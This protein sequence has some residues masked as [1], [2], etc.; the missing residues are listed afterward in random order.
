[1]APLPASHAGRT[2]ATCQVCHTET[3]PVPVIAHTV[4]GRGACTVCHGDGKIAPLPASHAG[5]TVA[6]CQVCHTTAVQP[7]AAPHRLDD[8]PQCSSCHT[9]GKVGALPPSHANRTDQMCTLCHTEISG[10]VPKIPHQIEGWTDCLMCH[11][12][13]SW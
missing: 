11:E 1:M 4:E 10:G 3:V 7:P 9:A 5:R 13:V 2:V 8:R 12:G 6:T